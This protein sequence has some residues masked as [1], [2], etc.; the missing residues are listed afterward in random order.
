[1]TSE[2]TPNTSGFSRFT[3]I[4]SETHQA[5]LASLA[6][7]YKLSQREILEALLD[8]VDMEKMDSTFQQM[9]VDKVAGREDKKGLVK[10]LS[11]L[12]PDQ[13]ARLQKMLAE[14]Q[15]AK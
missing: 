5:R 14:K 3:V 6:K 9:R 8:N 7:S 13:L 4:M 10:Q 2:N 1:M 11:A 12:N 15:D